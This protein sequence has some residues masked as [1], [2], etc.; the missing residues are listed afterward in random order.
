M[1]FSIFMVINNTINCN[2]E[3]MRW[4]LDKH[5]Q[6]MMA[7][8]NILHSQICPSAC[9]NNN[10][11]PP[12]I[13]GSRMKI[14]LKNTQNEHKVVFRLANNFILSKL[15]FCLGL[16]TWYSRFHAGLFL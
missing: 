6:M 11:L 5:A 9:P 12:A 10:H 15:C 13:P 16:C 8:C 7:Y 4:F 2:I 3:L 14:N 1:L